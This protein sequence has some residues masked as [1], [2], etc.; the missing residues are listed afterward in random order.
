MEEKF[1]D[2]QD[3]VEATVLWKLLKFCLVVSTTLK[4][5]ISVSWDCH[6]KYII[7]KEHFKPQTR[8][9]HVARSLQHSQKTSQ[10]NDSSSLAGTWHR[11]IASVG[12]WWVHYIPEYQV[13]QC[14]QNNILYCTILYHIMYIKNVI[15]YYIVR[16]LHYIML[17]YMIYHII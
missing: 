15:L 9:P 5:I 1:W 8:I 11:G 12:P 2:W 6:S 13:V 3:Y 17:Y 7:K 14:N 10:S 16:I 4:N